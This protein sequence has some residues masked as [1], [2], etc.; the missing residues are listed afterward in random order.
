[1]FTQYITEYFNM[2]MQ[3]I[4]TSEYYGIE[5]ILGIIWAA[6]CIFNYDKLKD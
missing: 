5:L 1:M 4:H 3:C 6:F 2:S